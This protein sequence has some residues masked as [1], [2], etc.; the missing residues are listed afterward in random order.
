M[1]RSIANFSWRPFSIFVPAIVCVAGVFWTAQQARSAPDASAAS[2][3]ASNGAPFM[4]A[5]WSEQAGTANGALEA[6]AHPTRNCM[7]CHR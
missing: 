7:R 1:I 2:P 3:A 5:E 4:S 6:M